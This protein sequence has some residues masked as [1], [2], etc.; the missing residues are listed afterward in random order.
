MH[1]YIVDKIRMRV[2]ILKEYFLNN[3]N[4]IILYHHTDSFVNS[5][6]HY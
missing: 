1:S 4:E 5:R 2:I 6:L 3:I